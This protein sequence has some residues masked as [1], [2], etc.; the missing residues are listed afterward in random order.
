[1]KNGRDKNQ[2]KKAQK[3]RKDALSHAA[4]SEPN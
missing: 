2:E 4:D 3:R 1:M